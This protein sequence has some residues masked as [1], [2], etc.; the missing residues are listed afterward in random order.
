MMMMM[1]HLRET[2]LAFV[3]ELVSTI[4]S[5]P[6]V[7]LVVSS[8]LSSRIGHH[9]WHVCPSK[10]GALRTPPL[11]IRFVRFLAYIVS[12]MNLFIDV[13]ATLDKTLCSQ[14]VPAQ[15][16]FCKARTLR[17][18]VLRS[19]KTAKQ[20]RWFTAQYA[21]TSYQKLYFNVFRL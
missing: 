3:W 13:V 1:H 6:Y 15:R 9:T 5:R 21:F 16:R 12:Y 8:K 18:P 11:H 19:V 7:V 10:A 17:A 4:A 2:D 14:T 20:E